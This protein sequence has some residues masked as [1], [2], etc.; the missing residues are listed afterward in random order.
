MTLFHVTS[1]LNRASITEHGL[2]WERM[3]LACGIAG[4]KTPEVPGVFLCIDEGDVDW[5]AF[6]INNTGG[7]VDVWAVDGV[8]PRSLRDNGNGYG[9]LAEK[10]PA[11]LLTLVRTDLA[12]PTVR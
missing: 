12:A 5:F 4:S 6:T 7:P 2:D 10:I 11:Y 9:Y 8:D 1:S 3:G